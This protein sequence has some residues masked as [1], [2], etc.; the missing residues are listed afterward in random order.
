MNAGDRKIAGT[1][2]EGSMPE[3]PLAVG[4]RVNSTGALPSIAAAGSAAAP[5]SARTPRPWSA[6]PG[7]KVAG[8]GSAAV[9]LPESVNSTKYPDSAAAARQY[10]ET[11]GLLRYVQ[12]ML[13]AIIQE[14]PDEPFTF[15]WNQL[16]A[17]VSVSRYAPPPVPRRSA[18][19][20]NDD[21][22]ASRPNGD[23]S[24]SAK[25]VPHSQSASSTEAAHPELIELRSKVADLQQEA[26][27]VEV[28]TKKADDLQIQLEEMRK[29]FEN[30]K[31]AAS[32]R[33]A[34]LQAKVDSLNK[35]VEAAYQKEAELQAKVDGLQTEAED[36]K[37]EACQKEAEL[38]AKVDGLQKEAEERQQAA[39]AREAEHQTMVDA[40]HKKSRRKSAGS[41]S[42][43]S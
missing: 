10:L 8:A 37:Q 9:V 40:L 28:A 14:R 12:A 31:Q 22:D 33:E 35:G 6:Q 4:V 43:R 30:T 7:I 2:M 41:F 15:M 17:A 26:G 27:K 21:A 36:R 25:S 16:G 29:R 38:Q 5:N 1:G 18:A 23:M 42:K 24:R 39:S 13:H 3:S 20:W 34:E 32:K 11:H 19:V